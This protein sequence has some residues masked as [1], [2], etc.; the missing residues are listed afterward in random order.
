MNTD[1]RKKTLDDG[2]AAASYR[3]SCFLLCVLRAS[4]LKL[5]LWHY[6]F[7][8]VFICGSFLFIRGS[9]HSRYASSASGNGSSA[10]WNIPSV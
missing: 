4:V 2:N 9:F 6:L 1:V 7:S 8:S 5:A 10:R 3:P